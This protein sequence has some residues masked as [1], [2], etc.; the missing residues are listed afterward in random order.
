[1]HSNHT[2]V[3][4]DPGSSERD[5]QLSDLLVIDLSRAVAGPHAAMMLGDL[6]SENRQG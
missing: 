3:S 6:G 5:G 2:E 1:V 4:E